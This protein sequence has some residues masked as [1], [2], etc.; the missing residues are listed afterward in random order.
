M[1]ATEAQKKATA[2]YN[3]ANYEQIAIRVPNGLKGQWKAA[4]EKAGVSLAQL[5]VEAV[6][7]EIENECL[8]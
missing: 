2:K 8:L 5:I 4:A 6:A 3:A 1:A 7:H